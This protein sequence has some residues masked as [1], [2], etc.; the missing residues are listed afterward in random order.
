MEAMYW[1][2]PMASRH[3]AVGPL[4][5]HIAGFAELIEEEGYPGSTA[6]RKIRLVVD[7]NQWLEKRGIE[8]A[9][10]DEEHAAAF[11]D[12]RADRGYCCRGDPT[13]LRVFLGH[14]RQAGVIPRPAVNN[15]QNPLERTLNNFALHL[16]RERA[17]KEVTSNIYLCEVRRFLSDR[18]A[19]GNVLLGKISPQDVSGFMLRRTRTV[20]P[21]TAQ[22]TTSALRS[23]LRFA[24]QR[25]D[26]SVDLAASVPSVANRRFLGIPKFLAPEQVE[27]LLRTCDRSAYGGKR[28]YAILL[29]L[30]RLGLRSGEVVHL[31]LDDIDWDAGE[32]LVR[33]KGS[34]HDRLP[35]PVDVGEALATYLRHGRPQCLSRHVFIRL[36]APRRRF[37]HSVCI[38]NIVRKALRR[39]ALDP[40][41]K[42]A[43]LL[44]HSLA[45]RMLREGATLA[46]IGTIL[47]HRLPNTTEI[48]AKVDLSALRALAQP[49][50]G[51]GHE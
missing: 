27:R 39:S 25:G 13:T 24:Y 14:L 16:L 42:G 32:L 36:R 34:R 46:E 26:V 5:A 11:L 9:D 38:C 23:F 47:R 21:R 43:H 44:R 17:L 33:G 35:I 50:P 6:N 19:T 20:S 49:W 12:H 10:F 8:L 48:Y 1:Q 40:S 28:D 30:A 2:A 37:A 45:T 7:L 3:Q 31:K 4:G 51:G 18:F 41:F 22:L 29:L 15:N